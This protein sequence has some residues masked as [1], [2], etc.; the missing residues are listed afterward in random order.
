[1][2]FMAEGYE[3]TLKRPPGRGSHKA[4]PVDPAS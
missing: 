3:G 1:M 2:V 4:V